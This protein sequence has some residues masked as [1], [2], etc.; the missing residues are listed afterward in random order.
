LLWSFLYLVVN[1]F[2]LVWLLAR[3]R[4][5]KELEMLVLRHELGSGVPLSQPASRM[6]ACDGERFLC[7]GLPAHPIPRFTRGRES[8]ALAF[9][10]IPSQCQSG[11]A[12]QTQASKAGPFSRQKRATMR[13]RGRPPAATAEECELVWVLAA[14]GHSQREIAEQVF[15]DRRFRGRV[16]RILRRRAE[17]QQRGR[18]S[19]AL[20]EFE[21]RGKSELSRAELRSA[22]RRQMARYLA[23]AEAG[24]LQA[25]LADLQR[26]LDLDLRLGLAEQAESTIAAARL[27][28]AG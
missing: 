28:D 5:S 9:S 11:P 1:L 23:R 21:R 3:S 13:M 7:R 8:G 20:D 27:S 6:P 18:A 24:E 2:A 4:R 22:V 19:E 16:E 26:L 17:G 14:A 12:S 10:P 15:G 25:S